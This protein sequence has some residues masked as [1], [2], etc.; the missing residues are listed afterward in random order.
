MMKILGIDTSSAVA[1]AA[2][3]SEEKLLAE[4]IL[5]HRHTHLEKLISMIDRLLTDSDTKLEDLD[6]IAVAIGPGSFTGIRIGMACAQ[7]LSHVYGIPLV[8]INTLDALAYNLMHC[9]DFICP[10]ID[11]QRGEVYT[12]LFQWEGENLKR[13]W[14]YEIVK[15]ERLAERLVDLD[16]RTIL[17]GDG[18]KLVAAVLPEEVKA[19]GKITFA[20]PL[21]VMPKASSVARAGLT[22]FQQGKTFNCFNIRPFYMRKS[23]AEEKWEERYGKG[24]PRK[25]DH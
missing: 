17:L 18:A 23:H 24:E 8:G 25:S 13:Y 14:D 2:L 19:S 21:F 22:E 15:A 6:A 10:A 3:L 20:N 5:N 11:A 1:T 4:Y 7:G 12:C 16:E 9:S